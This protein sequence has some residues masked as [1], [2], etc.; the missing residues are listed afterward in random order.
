MTMWACAHPEVPATAL[1][2]D[3]RRGVRTCSGLQPQVDVNMERGEEK[4]SAGKEA[5]IF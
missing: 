1:G 3:R 2:E 4:V 5:G